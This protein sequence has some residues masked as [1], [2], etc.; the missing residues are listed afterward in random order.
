MPKLRFRHEFHVETLEPD[1]VFLLSEQMHHT[2]TGRLYVLIAPL[3]DGRFD[4]AQITTE[5]R[6]QASPIQAQYTLSRLMR[7]GHV[8]EIEVQDAIPPEQAAYWS[9]HHT[10]VTARQSDLQVV[11][12]TLGEISAAAVT[13]AL[14]TFDFVISEAPHAEAALHIV[15]TDDYLNPELANF[16]EWALENRQAWLLAKP[17]GYV[18]WIGPIFQPAR[19]SACW[20][21]LAQRLRNNRAVETFLEQKLSLSAPLAL[22]KAALPTTL[23]TA[24]NMI[25]TEAAR[26]LITGGETAL[27]DDQLVTFDTLTLQTQ[28]HPLVK[29]PQCPACGDATAEL[30]RPINLTSRPPI[31]QRLAGY[32]SR[33]ADETY[34]RYKHHVSPITG[35][36]SRLDRV[37]SMGPLFV[38]AAGPNKARSFDDWKYM[39]RSLRSNAVG[40]GTDEMQAKVSGLCEALERYSGLFQGNEPRRIGSYHDMRDEAI[41]PAA[42]L[43]YSEAQ[44]LNR[45]AWNAAHPPHL[46][47]PQR[48]D[49]DRPLDWTPLWSLTENR[50]KYLP[51]AMCYYDYLLPEDHDFCSADSNGNAAG[52]SIEDAILQGF[53]ELVERENIALWWDNS[54]LCSGFELASID[55]SYLKQVRDYYASLRRELWVLDISSDLQIPTFVAISRRMDKPAQ[56]IIMGF[57][58]HFDASIAVMRAITEINQMLPS[59]LSI[60]LPNGQY[61]SESRW[62]IDWWQTATLTNE[63][64]LAP[65]LQLPLRTIADYPT[66]HTQDLRDDVQHCVDITTA[67]G[68]ELLVLDQT[69]ADIG[70]PVVKVVVPGMRHF[71]ARYAPGRLYDVPVQMGWLTA[72]TPENQ[73]NPRPMNL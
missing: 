36:V 62:E 44:Y 53:L 57:G 1:L 64:Y 4:A 38:Y 46:Y 26:W 33:S 23:Q 31:E 37:P 34:E 35:V 10:A 49:E 21:C 70:L 73:L 9:L 22:S 6:E 69:R 29:R 43:L 52:S 45:E 7:A 72:P 39:R 25:A 13:T 55:S 24:A 41:H 51:T 54:L 32:R 68:L 17:V 61:Y 8:I 59:V 60:D 27:R 67:H 30:P 48:F 18:Q 28:W 2:L 42:S 65:N 16:N 50:H 63:P 12:H 47:V 56:D 40:K 19:E 71:W 14:S 3:L 66:Y 5:L 15:L 11:V 58:A 20:Q